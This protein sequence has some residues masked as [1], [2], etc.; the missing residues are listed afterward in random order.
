[1]QMKKSI[2]FFNNIPAKHCPECGDQ[3]SSILN[4]T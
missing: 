1:M 4:P 2:E 3:L